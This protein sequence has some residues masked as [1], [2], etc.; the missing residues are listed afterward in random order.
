VWVAHDMRDHLRMLAEVAAARDAALEGSRIKSEFLANM[1]HEIRTP[2]NVVI[3][4]TDIVLETELTGSQREYLD[5]VRGSAVDLL[6]IISDV[7]DLYK[8]EAGK[9]TIERVPFGLRA[10]VGTAVRT[11]MV[12]AEEKCLALSVEVDPAVPDRVT[13]DPTRLRQVVLNLVSNAIK[14]TDTGEVAVRVSHDPGAGAETSLL[15][16]SVS[17]TG[18]GIA[19][20]QHDVIFD[21][22][23]Q[24]DGSMS[25][26]FGGTGLGLTIAARLVTM[27]GGRIW[28][29]STVGKGS[30]FHF[31]V[32]AELDRDGLAA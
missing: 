3:G 29:E 21:A 17:D 32:Q 18:I 24:A 28:V 13:G 15:H 19:A 11:L 14:F 6:D 20:D 4:Y 16:F 2:M 8:V 31:T 30:V 10:V 25:R 23:T 12:R 9:L 27:M 22:F 1:S 5:R 26:R 7:L